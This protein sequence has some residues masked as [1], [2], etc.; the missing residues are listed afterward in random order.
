MG[1]PRKWEIIVSGEQGQN[2]R[3]W[4]ARDDGR[5]QPRER[6]KAERRALKGKVGLWWRGWQ[7]WLRILVGKLGGEERKKK[8]EGKKERKK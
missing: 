4:E 1:S 7:L 2:Q 6:K 5:E 3:K 8:K